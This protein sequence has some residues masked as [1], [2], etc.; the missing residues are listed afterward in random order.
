VVDI[1]RPDVKRV[2]EYSSVRNHKGETGFIK[3]LGVVRF[4]E[5]EGPGLEEEDVSDDEGAKQ[6]PDLNGPTY[7]FWLE[8][9]IL[10]LC[11]VGLK[12][13]LVVHQLNI[14]IPFFDSVVGIYASFHTY[15]LNEKMVD[16]KEPSKSQY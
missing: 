1:V 7:P 16:W 11:F 3:P 8:D 5:W 14:G 4:K 2:E 15:L 6:V 12:L 10:Q 13:E 9:E